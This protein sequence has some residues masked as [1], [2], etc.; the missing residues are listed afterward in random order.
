MN[1]L[2]FE[3]TVTGVIQGHSIPQLFIPKL[4]DL[5]K[6]GIFPFDKLITFYEFKDINKAVE[7]MNNGT[8]LKPVLLMNES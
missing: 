7:E 5:Y 6:Q 2:V 4:I 1:K 8:V 3:K